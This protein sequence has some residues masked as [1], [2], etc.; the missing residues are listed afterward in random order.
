MNFDMPHEEVLA[1][2][3]PLLDLSSVDMQAETVAVFG[4]AKNLT[5]LS[6]MPRLR[7]LWLS[8]VNEKQAVILKSLPDLASLVVHDWRLRSLEAFSGLAALEFLAVC[9]SGRLKSLHGIESLRNLRT[10][11]LQTMTGIEALDP[12]SALPHLEV[13][14]IEG[15]FSRNLRLP[16]LQ[17]LASLAR[18]RRLRLAGVSVVDRSLR[19]LHGLAN[20][21]DI[22]IPD[23]FPR[24]QM[25][26]LANALPL[27]RGEYLDTYRDV[28]A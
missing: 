6:E 8:G 14:S 25:R 9:G 21:R 4:K 12:L 23:V 15:T 1:P 19:P 20:V 26:D 10:L 5:R 18:L 22:F 7:H 24:Q 2:S 27:A 17:P 16:S 28:G 3:P 11:I 13:L